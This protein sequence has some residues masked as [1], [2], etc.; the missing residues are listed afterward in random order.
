M[1]WLKNFVKQRTTSQKIV[2]AVSVLLLSSAMLLLS[3]KQ[4]VLAESGNQTILT[5]LQKIIFSN[6]KGKNNNTSIFSNTPVSF[7]L[8]KP[9]PAL[10]TPSETYGG[11]SSIGATPTPMPG[12]S[13]TSNTTPT[14]TQTASNVLISINPSAVGLSVPPQIDGISTETGAICK[15]LS[16][17]SLSSTYSQLYKN[18]GSEMLRIGG[19]SGDQ[20][21]WSPSGTYCPASPDAIDEQ[22]VNNLVTFVNKIGWKFTWGVDLGTYDPTDMASEANYVYNE[23]GSTLYAI[24]I[25]NEPNNFANEGYRTSGYNGTSFTTEWQAYK[26]AILG[27]NP[28]IPLM[29]D[30][31][32]QNVPWYSTFMSSEASSLILSGYHLYPTASTG[33]GPNAPTIANLLSQSL[34]NNTIGTIQTWEAVAKE[35]NVPFALTEVNSTAGGGKSGVSNA[36]AS[37]LW[38]A[39]YIFTAMEQGVQRMNFHAVGGG[40]SY[41]AIDSS[42]NVHPLYYGLLFFHE[43]TANGGNVIMPSVHATTNTT[44]HVILG[45][46][47]KLYVAV[48][49]KDLTNTAIVDIRTT[50]NYSQA[51]VMYMTAPSVSSTSGVTF[52]GAST[53]ANGTWSPTPSSLQIINGTDTYIT[54]SPAE[55]A[56]VTL[57]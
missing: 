11:S 22:E 47:G 25:G 30:D 12:A 20:A 23:A 1:E 43:A 10:L 5:T 52:G 24:A 37:A 3:A 41:E 40:A 28:S 31:Q 14:S 44:A 35:Y 16:Q 39:D 26:T 46:D 21:T 32:S 51:S 4:I 54:L 45:G 33:T 2:L 19:N 49:N 42:G 50:T 57:Q 38:S 17:D 34:M 56:L 48:I 13:G 27:I 8:S 15:I 55:A 36:F 6:T 18:L 29:G 53:A 9:S 7:L